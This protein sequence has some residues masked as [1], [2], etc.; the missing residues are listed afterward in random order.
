M[1]PNQRIDVGWYSLLYP[2]RDQ[3]FHWRWLSV[4]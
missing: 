4:R 1:P 3:S 2:D